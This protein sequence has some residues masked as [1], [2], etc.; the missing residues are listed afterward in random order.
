MDACCTCATLLSAAPRFS[1]TEKPLPENRQLPCCARVI[2]GYCIHACSLHTVSIVL[3]P[4]L[5]CPAP[6]A[7]AIPVVGLILPLHQDQPVN[8][9]RSP[10]RNR[11][12]PGLD[13][14]VPIV[15]SPLV[16]AAHPSSTAAPPPTPPLRPQTP[17]S[18][19][20][21]PLTHPLPQLPPGLA[22]AAPPQ[23]KRRPHSQHL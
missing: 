15:K 16:A 3:Y 10:T 20:P 12:I 8:A 14:T 1:E 11:E 6:R 13:P 21:R 5:L 9:D 17:T 23:T 7:A 4:A 2:C 22:A 18:S 19:P